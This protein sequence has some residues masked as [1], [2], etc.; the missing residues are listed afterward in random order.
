M[1]V[2]IESVDPQAVASTA[3]G[4]LQT[5]WPTPRLRY[6]PEELSWQFARPGW[7]RPRGWLARDG[8]G[9]AVAFAAALPRTVRHAGRPREVWLTSFYAAFGDPGAAIRLLRSE[10]RELK[11]AGRPSLVFAAPASAGEAMLRCNDAAGL[12]R[13]AL[14]VARVHAGV[15]G[16]PPPGAVTA[17]EATPA[18]DGEVADLI[19]LDRRDGV[20][21]DA[22]TPQTLRHDRADP[23]GRCWAVVRGP[24]GSLLAAACTH[25]SESVTADG[26][27]RVATL[28]AVTLPREGAGEALAALVGFA[29]RR[30]ADRATSAVVTVPNP[31]G[32]PAE[33]LRAARLRALPAAW[34][35]YAFCIDP[36][37]PLL[38]ATATDLE[39]I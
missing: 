30:W 27:T 1:S 24:T 35:A 32:I 10:V 7:D 25:L 17:R 29:A 38:T 18:D 9:R 20:I 14:A 21:T 11:A 8:D 22:V 36:A 13:N 23:R 34:A 33:A 16:A 31:S 5:A 4:V 3:A 39:V 19:A 2:V 28:S 26:Q 6:G 15:P 37:D 12:K